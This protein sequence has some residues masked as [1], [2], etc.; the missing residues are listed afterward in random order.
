MNKKK[1]VSCEIDIVL[2]AQ[3][4]VLLTVS[5]FDTE[6]DYDKEPWIPFNQDE[7]NL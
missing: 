5:N 1:F 7:E 3:E 4:E 2:F 6:N